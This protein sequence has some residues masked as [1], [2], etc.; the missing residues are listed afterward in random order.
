MSEGRVVGVITQADVARVDQ[1][2]AAELVEV[3]SSARDN[4]ARG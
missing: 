1:H 2:L 3:I 4:T